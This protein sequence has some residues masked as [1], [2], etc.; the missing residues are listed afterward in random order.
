MNKH[1]TTAQLYS[2]KLETKSCADSNPTHS[3][4]QVCDGVNIRQ[5]KY[6][7]GNNMFKVNNKNTRTKCERHLR[8]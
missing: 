3:L 2:T 6:L 4:L 8:S 7:A 1:I 5:R